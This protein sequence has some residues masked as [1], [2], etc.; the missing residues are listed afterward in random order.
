MED[1]T[2]D[3]D[4][5]APVHYGDGATEEP[6]EDDPEFWSDDDGGVSDRE[7]I[8]RVWV[9]EGQLTR[10]RI[11]PS[12][13]V[14]LER[15]KG[16]TLTDVANAVLQVAHVGVAGPSTVLQE[17][18]H[19]ELT[20]EF[21]R[22]LPDATPTTLEAMSRHYANKHKEFSKALREAVAHQAATAPVQARSEGVTVMLNARGQA[23]SLTIDE[24]WLGGAHAGGISAAIV[25][26]A[27]GAYEQYAAAPSPEVAAFH[28]V[29]REYEYLRKVMNTIL[30]P[31]DRR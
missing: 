25:T 2:E 4:L 21:A 27:R 11:S 8:I 1:A 30:V 3:E 22:S 24:A 28:E 13:A 12:W 29:A 6:D 19:V 7:R 9:E 26:A 31:K 18:P 17:A 10:V 14:K 16:A 15:R 20:K 23:T 5:L